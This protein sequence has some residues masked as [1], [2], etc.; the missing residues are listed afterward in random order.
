MHGGGTPVT[1]RLPLRVELLGPLRVVVDGEVVDVPGLK[2][3][4]VLALLAASEGQAI[5]VDE[6][7]QSVWPDDP[8]DSGRRALHSHISRLRSHLGAAR[9]R[10]VRDGDSYRLHLEDA[11]LDVAEARALVA[12]AQALAATDPKAAV[13]EL[14]RG[15]ALWR[16]TAMEEFADIPAL[17]TQ[18]VALAELRREM[19]DTW[20]EARLAAGAGSEGALAGD[21][22]AAAAGDP[23]HERVH[24]VAMAA[25]A[26]EGRS[27]EAMRLAHDFRERLA[28]QTGLD[29]SPRF[30]QLEQEIAAGALSAPVTEKTTAPRAATPFVGRAFELDRVIDLAVQPGLISIVGPGGVG[31]TR[32]AQEVIAVLASRGRE[33]LTV[34]LATVDDPDDVVDAVVTAL[35][36]RM[37]GPTDPWLAIVERLR[38]GAP[39]LALDNCE[40]LTSTC[41]ELVS[42]LGAECDE[43]TILT[44]SREPLRLGAEQLVRLGPLPVPEA[45]MRAVAEL[46]AVPAFDAFVRH[47]RRK[48]ATFDLDDE[49]AP[50]AA[51]IVRRLDGLPLALELAAGRVSSLGLEGLRSR[52][53]RALDL[54]TGPTDHRHETLRATIEWSY[55]LLDPDGQRLVRALA[56][57]PAG[58]DLDTAEW[59]GQALALD[60]DPASALT[61]VVE[62]SVAFVSGESGGHYRFLEVVRGFLL[63]AL[64]AAG[65][66]E[67]VEALLA[68]WARH[69]AGLIGE[70]ARSQAEADAHLRLRRNLGNI[71]AAWAAA[72]S[73]GDLD[74]LVAIVAG[75]DEFIV[76]QGTPELRE[77]V[78]ALA[79]DDRL[80]GHPG[81]VRVL[82]GAG[83]SAWMR[84]ELDRAEALAQN[85]ISSERAAGRDRCFDSIAAVRLFRGRFDEAEEAWLAADR[86]RGG[87]WGEYRTSAA[88][89]ASYAGR[90]DDAVRHL[91]EAAAVMERESSPSHRAYWHY[92]KAEVTVGSDPIAAQA[93]YAI[94]VATAREVGAGFV[95][96]VASVGLV[97]L[98]TRQQEHGK[99]LEGFGVLLDHWFRV[100]SW[101]Q[102][103][104]TLRNL[105]ALLLEIGDPE[106]A[107]L[108]V[109]AADLAPDAALPGPEEAAIR[110]RLADQLDTDALARARQQA[111]MN[112]RSAIYRS[113]VDAVARAASAQTGSSRTGTGT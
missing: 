9:D 93:D 80:I 3:R 14:G 33:V 39:L 83:R 85:G 64:D 70:T 104:T 113:A 67:Q 94:A 84:G 48:D 55:D 12:D 16:G 105:S 108:L 102:L 75:I 90:T 77:S 79:E 100:G 78:L 110:R 112:P 24:V 10:L 61:R 73:L 88:L 22:L 89:A 91:R 15:L 76:R 95:E 2:R 59:F 4:A 17:A 71:R 42:R 34:E 72:D 49:S 25:L 44:T 60:G 50:I 41:R 30:L 58:F 35:D 65:E 8:P 21:A 68:R 81:R 38:S 63:E 19:R 32:L 43:L 86:E 107:A 36:L 69:L 111:S 87:V 92:V 57:L 46:S 103:W 18:A 52:L 82:G 7:Y 37:T 109:E 5:S 13:D 1:R 11:E 96:G 56:V 97:A 6:I 98:W 26:R 106:T 29:P 51:E 31:K 62:A 28:D 66:R 53:N 74:T 99:A 20:L 23:L 27:A 47:A 40:H 101:T 45:G 54:L